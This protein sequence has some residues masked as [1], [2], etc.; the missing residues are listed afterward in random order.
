MVIKKYKTAIK[1][2]LIPSSGAVQLE[3]NHV[4]LQ[5]KTAPPFSSYSL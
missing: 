1:H 2:S 5:S 3:N 4:V